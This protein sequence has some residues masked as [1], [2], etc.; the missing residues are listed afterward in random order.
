MTKGPLGLS[1]S[2]PVVVSILPVHIL[3]NVPVLSAFDSFAIT[4]DICT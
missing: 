2:S 4:L 1:R 3:Q